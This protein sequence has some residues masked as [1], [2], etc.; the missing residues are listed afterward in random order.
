M[1]QE[2]HA[3]PHSWAVRLATGCQMRLFLPATLCDHILLYT[4]YAFKLFKEGIG[5]SEQVCQM[6]VRLCLTEP[7]SRSPLDRTFK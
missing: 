7:S 1:K 5:R 4:F 3:C 6:T 2:K